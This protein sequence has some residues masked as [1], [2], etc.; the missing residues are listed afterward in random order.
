MSPDGIMAARENCSVLGLGKGTTMR[1]PRGWSS[2]RRTSRRT[3]RSASQTTE[4]VV[5]E[6]TSQ[7]TGAAFEALGGVRAN[8]APFLVQPAVRKSEEPPEGVTT[9]SDE[10]LVD[11]DS[12]ACS[13]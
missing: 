2:P 10:F 4:Y 5:T 3:I 8:F 11:R 1:E 9:S 13:T 12:G 7:W 6:A